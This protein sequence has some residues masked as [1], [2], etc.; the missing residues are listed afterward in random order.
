MKNCANCNQ[1]NAPEMSF[2]LNC[3]AELSQISADDMPATVL[4]GNFDAFPPTQNFG[5]PNNQQPN[6]QS[7]QQQNFQQPNFQ[8][9]F[10][11]PNFQSVPES[12][13]NTNKILLGVGGLIIGL[14]MLVSGGVALYK[15]FGSSSSS[16]SQTLYPN[17]ANTSNT[18]T[19]NTNT[20]N[21]NTA[22]NTSSPSS[23]SSRTI[24]SLT[25]QTVG[26]WTLR[27]T[28]TGD[29]EKDGFSGASEEKQFKYYNSSGAMVHL[30]IAE[31]R[32]EYDAQK[33]LRTSMQKFKTLKLKVG[34]EEPAS[35]NDQN[36][37][38]ITQTMA[39]ANGK[40]FT[41]YWT[42]KNFLFRALGTETDVENFFK[43]SEN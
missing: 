12:G 35:D 28:I 7:N 13:G 9:N 18:N 4:G 6:F 11:P 5:Q 32:Y 21:T 10:Q 23:S 43:K 14:I 33:S 36:E 15:V 16:T 2:C 31:Y 19:S 8:P 38:G 24:A 39:S 26:D 34:E 20:L 41:R 30:T 3:G 17:N 40:I 42:N 29:A 25:Q 22:K 1:S 27:D 37:I